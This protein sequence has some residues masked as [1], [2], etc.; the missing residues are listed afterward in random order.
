MVLDF[1]GVTAVYGRPGTGKTSLAMRIAHEYVARGRHVLWVS[2][3]EDRET[4]FKNAAALGYDLSKAEFWD[5][6][7]IRPDIIMNQIVSAASQGDYSLVV[8]DS[9][10]SLVAELQS[11]EYLINAVYRVFKP[12]GIDFIGIA[13]EESAAPLDYIADNLLRME[14]R[15]ENGIAERR[16]YV[17]KARGRRAG[18]YVEFDILEGQGVVFLDDLPR[19]A[20]KGPW[21]RPVDSLSSA[22]GPVRGGRVYLFAGRGLTP[23]LARVAAELSREGLKVLYRVFFRDVSA[24]SALVEKF[25]GRAV[26]Q[27]VEPRPQSHFAHIKG[28]YETL[29]ETDADVLISE[30]VDVE[31][32][33]YGKKALEINR[34]E[35]GELRK[36]GIA[37]FLNVDREYGLRPFADVFVKVTG[38]QAAVYSA[39][40]RALCRLEAA[41]AP[42]LVC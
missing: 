39:H 38:D 32:L 25:G 2:L 15:L 8:V 20:T 6:I 14:L 3:Y 27:R 17:I 31:F 26:V 33:V 24:A 1:R 42:R 11:R 5:M 30:G 16:M 35:L 13:E 7:F 9:I 28:L 12:A 29:A 23:L 19:P 37:V 34:R 10:S 4:F 36:L 40:G 18:Y 41:P 21:E 22:V